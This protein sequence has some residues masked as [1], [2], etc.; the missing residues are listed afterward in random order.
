M[1]GEDDDP[2]IVRHLRTKAWVLPMLNDARRNRMYDDAVR[3]AC[4]IAVGRRLAAGEESPSDDDDDD[5]TEGTAAKKKKKT[6]IRILD[7]GSG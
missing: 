5:A 4:R 1:A 3:E 7:I 6:T 2:G